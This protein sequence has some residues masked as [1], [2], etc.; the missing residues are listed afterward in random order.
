MFSDPLTVTAGNVTIAY[1][2]ASYSMIRTDG[3]GSERRDATGNVTTNLVLNHSNSKSGER[4][5]AKVSQTVL[6][7]GPNSIEVPVTGSVSISFA[8]PAI[9]TEDI[10]MS[11]LLGALIGLLTGDGEGTDLG[12]FL[13]SWES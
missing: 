3:Y 6:A 5:Y 7:T 11:V 8:K 10:D 4:H 13:D 12:R 2:N 9:A 1:G